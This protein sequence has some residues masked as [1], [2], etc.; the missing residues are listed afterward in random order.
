V[1]TGLGALRNENV[2]AGIQ[3]RLCHVFT[4]NLTDQQGSRGLDAGRKWFGIPKR[5]HDRARPDVQRDIQQFG[6]LRQAPGDEADAEGRLHRLELAGLL[7]EPT[8]VAIAAAKNPK[9]AGAAHR[10]RQAGAGNHIHRRQ[11][12]RM[13][14]VQKS[15]Q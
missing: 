10:C 9:T 14:D 7:F 12:Y 8:P 4:L 11:Q 13:H 3:R 15:G 6:L 5:E 1:P 2:G